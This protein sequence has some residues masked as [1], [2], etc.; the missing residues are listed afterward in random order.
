MLGSTRN[1]KSPP[2]VGSAYHKEGLRWVSYSHL[3]LPARLTTQLPLRCINPKLTA[4]SPPRAW[5]NCQSL[6][7]GGLVT[8]FSPS[9]YFLQVIMMVRRVNRMLQMELPSLGF[10]CTTHRSGKSRLHLGLQNWITT[11]NHFIV[12]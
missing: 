6:S 3:D 2:S 7:G 8:I 5:G 9:K 1:E 4:G 11:S 12:V 10:C